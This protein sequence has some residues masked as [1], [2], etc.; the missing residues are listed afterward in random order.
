MD[1]NEF[2]GMYSNYL[3]H[4]WVTSTDAALRKKQE[5][6]QRQYNAEY[7]RKHRGSRLLTPDEARNELD[8]QTGAYL[9]GPRR[10]GDTRGMSEQEKK[11]HDA[12]IAEIKRR[13]PLYT[14]EDAERALARM[15]QNETKERADVA[16]R[17][18]RA[19]QTAQNQTA[20]A[21]ASAE[22]DKQKRSLNRV[23]DRDVQASRAQV[24]AAEARRA[25]SQTTEEKI[26]R[27]VRKVASVIDSGIAKVQKAKDAYNKTAASGKRI[28]DFT[29]R[30]LGKYFG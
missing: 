21:R 5:E 27:G 20:S 7:Y 26:K 23:S 12:R 9:V 11:I 22:Y 3:A 16:A 19:R 13:A 1:N 6:R 30:T 28:M 4:R 2:M 25:K 10:P 29:K 15:T 24:K 17:N 14:D 18:A 8:A